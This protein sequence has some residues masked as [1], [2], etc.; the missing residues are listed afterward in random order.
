LEKGK[1]ERKNVR[2]NK[3]EKE[4]MEQIKERKNKK[5]QIQ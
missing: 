2:K 1:A 5:G 3:C 4:Y